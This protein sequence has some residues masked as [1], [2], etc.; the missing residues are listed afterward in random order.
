MSFV[1]S[2]GWILVRFLF[3]EHVVHGRIHDGEGDGSAHTLECKQRG[4]DGAQGEG[5]RSVSVQSV[6]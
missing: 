6:S 4:L 3:L 5:L 2:F 1:D